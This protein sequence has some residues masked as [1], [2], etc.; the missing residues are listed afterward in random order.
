LKLHSLVG[1]P[2]GVYAYR[3]AIRRPARASGVLGPE[4]STGLFSP[5]GFEP[6]MLDIRNNKT[7]AVWCKWENKNVQKRENKNVQF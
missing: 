7:D 4:Q 1:T 6:L 2:S 3:C 5:C